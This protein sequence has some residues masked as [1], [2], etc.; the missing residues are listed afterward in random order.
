MF[1]NIAIS[2]VGVKKLLCLK[3]EENLFKMELN[4][5]TAY[6][7]HEFLVNGRAAL[8]PILSVL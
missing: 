6:V 4:R 1:L 8:S 5:N 2:V 3:T 7:P